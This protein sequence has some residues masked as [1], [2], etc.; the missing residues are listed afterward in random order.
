MQI[1]YLYQ[2]TQLTMLASF[3]PCLFVR[4]YAFKEG[5]IDFLY[6]LLPKQPLETKL[7]FEEPC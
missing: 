6:Y 4:V 7:E 2:N 3:W 1:R 5:N